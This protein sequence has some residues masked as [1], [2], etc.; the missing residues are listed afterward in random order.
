MV[1]FGIVYG[2]TGFGLADRLNIPRKEGEEFVARYLERFPAVRAFREEIVEK[3]QEEGFVTTLMGRRRPIPELRSGNPNTRRLGER[4]AVN[5]VIQGTAADII[6]VAMVR[7]QRALRR[8]R[9][10]DP[11]GPA[12]PRRAA[13]RGPAGGDGGRDRAG[14][15]RD[16]RRLPAR[17]AARGRH[18]RR[19]RLARRQVAQP[20]SST[21]S[22]V[23]LAV[24]ELQ[25]GLAGRPRR[26]PGRRWCSWRRRRCRRGRSGRS[27][28]NRGR[29]RRRRCRRRARSRR[30]GAEVVAGRRSSSHL[31]F[32][33]R[34][35][36][37]R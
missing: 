6:K 28:R 11:A 37:G 33:G 21:S 27:S 20:A 23:A 30:C 13:L 19:P 10:G 15:A 4:L 34:G 29:S 12:D 36:A 24:L 18:R 9:G 3:A 32:V 25:L 17:S 26:G 14:A 7:C 31:I 5:T 16:V 22:K 8:G 35:D 2:L 1:N